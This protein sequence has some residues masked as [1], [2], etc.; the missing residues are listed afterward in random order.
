ML[1]RAR[2][3]SP[4]S[5]ERAD[6]FPDNGGLSSADQAAAVARVKAQFDGAQCMTEKIAALGALVSKQDC[7]EREAAVAAFHSAAAGDALVLNKWFAIQAMADR[8]DLLAAVQS[9]KQHK[10]F[11][12][13][14]PNRARSLISSF[15][16]NMKHFHAS[17][18]RGYAFIADCVLELDRLNPQ[19]A[20]RL[21][22]AFSQWRR[23]DGARQALIRAQLERIKAAD[24]LSKD[25]FEIVTR[26][27][28]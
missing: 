10:D 6:R 2:A 1:A 8:P 4:R 15:A 25:T 14:N 11:I 5:R 19:V 3:H 16:G 17:D 28:K 21:T 12:L 24:G 13:S 26:S 9:L 20:S 22:T 18:G 27:L 23:F 7:P